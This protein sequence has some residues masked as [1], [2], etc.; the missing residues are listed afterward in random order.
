MRTKPRLLAIIALIA[1]GSIAY[2]GYRVVIDAPDF[3]IRRAAN[4][5]LAN[6]ERTLYYAIDTQSTVRVRVLP[7]DRELRIVSHLNAPVERPHDNE[8]EYVYGIRIQELDAIGAPLRES[9]YWE[10]SRVTRLA[11]E[12]GGEWSPAFYFPQQA[13]TP[14]DGRLTAVVLPYDDDATRPVFLD[15]SLR[16]DEGWSG[17]I[18]LY[19]RVERA[20]NERGL[21]WSRLGG[22]RRTE[23]AENLVYEVDMLTRDERDALTRYRWD[24]VFAEGRR[25][26]EYRVESIYL[27]DP[28]SR[29]PELPS[30]FTDLNGFYVDASRAAFLNVEGAANLRILVEESGATNGTY[31]VEQIGE[32]GGTTST[33]VSWGDESYVLPIP[34]GLQTVSIHTDSAARFRFE[35]DAPVVAPEDSGWTPLTPEIHTATYYRVAAS[36]AEPEIRADIAANSRYGG[37][38]RLDTRQISDTNAPSP[39]A[40]RVEYALTDQSGGEVARGE[41]HVPAM[42]A[43][44]AWFDVEAET[45][46]DGVA[47][48]NSH[49]YYVPIPQ[50]AAQ[51]TVRGDVG[52]VVAFQASLGVAP[53][54]EVG[55][56]T[57][58]PNVRLTDCKQ[59]DRRWFRFH[60]NNRDALIA[61]D[62]RATLRWQCRRVRLRDALIDDAMSE[63]DPAPVVEKTYSGVTPDVAESSA[64]L[65]ERLAEHDAPEA[66]VGLGTYIDMGASPTRFLVS[67]M[68]NSENRLPVPVDLIPR[69]HVASA[70]PV[71]MNG[72]R[73]EAYPLTESVGVMR[74]DRASLGTVSFRFP[75]VTGSPWYIN[76]PP[77]VP[78]S[79]DRVWRRRTVYPLEFGSSV[80]V[81]VRKSSSERVT[82]NVVLHTET[83]DAP[84]SVRATLVNPPVPIPTEQPTDRERTYRIVGWEPIESFLVDDKRAFAA[85][86]RFTYTLREDIPA[87][88][89]AIRFDLTDGSAARVRFFVAEPG[90][91]VIDRIHDAVLNVAGPTQLRIESDTPNRSLKTTR[92]NT[93]GELAT[94]TIR[95]DNAGAATLTVPLGLQ[96]FIIASDS[97][98]TA[99]FLVSAAGAIQPGMY[100]LPGVPIESDWL[101]MEPDRV[102]RI[103]VLA[104]SQT[105]LSMNVTP[106]MTAVRLTFRS[107]A[108]GTSVARRIEYAMKSKD[109]ILLFSGFADTLPLPTDSAARLANAPDSPV[110]EAETF[111][112]RLPNVAGT[113]DVWSSDGR[114]LIAADRLSAD[115]RDTTH[116]PEEL[117]KNLPTIALTDTHPRKW[118]PLTP[119][120]LDALRRA[121]RLR[122]IES[123]TASI[124]QR[125]PNDEPPTEFWRSLTP[126][127]GAP[128]AALER[129]S[130]EDRAA[131][132]ALS[133]AYYPISTRGTAFTVRHPGGTDAADVGVDAVYIR[134]SE[135]ATVL[136][137]AVDG[138]PKAF[139]LQGRFG[140]IT[141][142]GVPVGNRSLAASTPNDP[143]LRV[144]AQGLTARPTTPS[145]EIRLKRT[146][147]HLRRDE[148]FTL[149]VVKSGREAVSV[150]IGAYLAGSG[151]TASLETS[152]LP[153]AADAKPVLAEDHTDLAKTFYLKPSTDAAPD[154]LIVMDAALDGATYRAVDV[155]SVRLGDDLPPGRYRIRG[156]LRGAT[157]ALMRFFEADASPIALRP[158]ESVTF[159]LRGEGAFRIKHTEPLR[160][161]QFAASGAIRA[162]NL[163]GNVSSVDVLAGLVTL[164]VTNAGNRH[165]DCRFYVADPRAMLVDVVFPSPTGLR[166]VRP[167]RSP[168]DYVVA[169]PTAPLSVRLDGPAGES[170]VARV[171]AVVPLVADGASRIRWSVLDRAG[172]VVGEG[173]VPFEAIM[174]TDAFYADER[175]HLPS[176]P[177][178]FYL[179]IPSGS[180][181][182][183]LTPTVET[184][185][186]VETRPDA[187]IRST[188]LDQ[189]TLAHRLKPSPEPLTDARSFSGVSELALL[190]PLDDDPGDT[191]TVVHA[192]RWVTERE[193]QLATEEEREGVSL[194][195]A[196][197]DTKRLILQPTDEFGANTLVGIPS[198]TTLPLNVV[199][200]DLPDSSLPT[201]VRVYYAV[202]EKT[203]AD[204]TRPYLTIT[205]DEKTMRFPLL[206]THDRF[207][208]PDVTAGHHQARIEPTGINP[209]AVLLW[210][211]QQIVGIAP[212]AY[213]SLRTAYT[214]D[215]AHPFVV[216]VER[217][218]ATPITLNVP[219]AVGKSPGDSSGR[220]VVRA[221]VEGFKRSARASAAYTPFRREYEISPVGNESSVF[222][223]VNA[224]PS[225]WTTLFVPLQDDLPPG[226]YHVRIELVGEGTLWS[227]F[228]VMTPPTV[229]DSVRFSRGRIDDPNP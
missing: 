178:T 88:D 158:G 74:I 30:P 45:E 76:R 127:T 128:M 180:T 212:D 157:G 124:R 64:F 117:A 89:Y 4:A 59:Q 130:L 149:E 20:E 172:S 162:S 133:S 115:Y 91:T 27:S 80:V 49:S 129:V 229:S 83:G 61:A 187:L 198:G 150:N 147:Y 112:L 132:Y 44:S 146:Y 197:Y 53:T 24:R 39:D 175:H 170:G 104:S 203:L 123:H 182:I 125:E 204:A 184:H 9:V 122:Q 223:T 19:R 208:V 200:L 166:E 70:I 227:R 47:A 55:G 37:I 113:L 52:V 36:P 136:N 155:F 138:E 22:K 29:P 207:T 95:L 100:R 167:D 12:K 153:D 87:G 57:V 105:P 120:R 101:P 194:I 188:V 31:R 16:H 171:S 8:T 169:S 143:S 75:N 94:T 193:V 66:F 135:S 79:R 71:E 228:F 42:I 6:A 196:T 106:D 109:G 67:D 3:D 82:L 46:N 137:L 225:G 11:D 54:V 2:V 28:D 215:A 111:T 216:A 151:P 190:A 119:L 148:P 10:K 60:P 210:I 13:V 32:S 15:I 102:T 65:L 99:R 185:F 226:R 33:L 161:K 86:Q 159:N 116:V 173:S 98:M 38:I 93:R 23:L 1:F 222:G 176:K 201:D 145:D 163:S 191:T 206:A 63:N 40:Y 164:E 41:Y 110:A 25:G 224:L 7:S 199:N 48:T 21:A 72:T 174:S 5:Q 154:D 144:Y 134:R 84:M 73:A 168:R 17:D 126:S 202:A 160:V 90:G 96:T 18:R 92:L 220:F 221:T 14:T 183:R 26:R 131:P 34:E 107:L 205:L 177:L 97:P 189:A 140:L 209:L 218:D 152:I 114:A 56:A 58:A 62:R 69:G 213:R 51:I 139:E 156:V 214:T 77:S 179:S 81:P 141:A 85:K 165:A 181:E 211:D 50:N 192:S 108:L 35:R 118:T 219:V 78:V 103:Y 142:T 186:R 121:N 195:P 43:D 217:N 68:M